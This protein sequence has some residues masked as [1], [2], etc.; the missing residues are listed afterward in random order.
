MRKVAQPLLNAATV[1]ATLCAITVVGMRLRQ[2]YNARQLSPLVGRVADW[3][4]YAS[5][6]LRD[7]PTDAR[8]QIVEFADFQCPYCRS[9]SRHLDSL[10][11]V[12]SREVALIYR[13]YPIHRYAH[14]AAV[15][16]ECA[17]KQGRFPALRRLLFATPESIGIKPWPTFA[18]DAGVPNANAFQRCLTT[19]EVETAVARDSAAAERLRIEG[20]PTFLINDVEIGGYDGPELM[21]KVLAKELSKRSP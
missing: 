4:A 15:A 21:D 16:A 12:H 14:D 1:V 8:V 3:R 19:P 6:G 10:L 17:A 2:A 5:A 13:H 20:T 7:G 9:A 11:S 18:R